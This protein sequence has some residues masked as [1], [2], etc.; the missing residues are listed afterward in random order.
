MKTLFILSTIVVMVL[1]TLNVTGTFTTDFGN[2][3]LQQT[4]NTVTGT[5]S[6][7]SNG[8]TVYGSIK[9]ILKENMLTFTWEQKQG[10]GKSGGEGEFNFSKDGKS[11]KGSWKD[12]KGQTGTWNG[13]K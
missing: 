8:E 6:Y 10:A 3:Q 4:K 13:K 12:G 5:Y 1:T 7:P 11:F 9:G 2:L